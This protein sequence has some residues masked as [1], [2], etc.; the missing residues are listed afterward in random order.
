MEFIVLVL[1]A[2]A[3]FFFGHVTGKETGER[4]SSKAKLGEDE[5]IR[6]HLESYFSEQYSSPA[7]GVR[8]FQYPYSNPLSEP[9]SV[10]KTSELSNVLICNMIHAAN[11]ENDKKYFDT[12]YEHLSKKFLL[13]ITGQSTHKS[14]YSPS[15][16]AYLERNFKEFLVPIE[17]I[18]EDDDE[19]A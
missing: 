3:A 11:E 14:S 12:C 4:E 13:E 5:A 1:V 17:T 7:L 2:A 9:L 19:N 18:S 6:G 16:V 10:V 8:H 15:C